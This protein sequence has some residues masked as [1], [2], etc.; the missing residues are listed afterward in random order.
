MTNG[1]LPIVLSSAQQVTTDSLAVQA[2]LFSPSAGSSSFALYD[3]QNNQI[4]SCN[5][6][7][8]EPFYIPFPKPIPCIGLSLK[9]ISSGTL[10]VYLA[11]I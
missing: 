8:Q 3:S 10:Y 9:A 2:L 7:D 4:A 11:D 6:T 5:F 1:R